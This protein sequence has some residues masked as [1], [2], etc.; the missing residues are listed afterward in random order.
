MSNDEI[1]AAKT[2]WE[3]KNDESLVD[4]LNS[5]T[6]GGLREIIVSLLT[7]KRTEADEADEVRRGV[8]RRLFLVL[9]S[10]T[11]CPDVCFGTSKVG[12]TCWHRCDNWFYRPALFES[13][14]NVGGY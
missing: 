13:V 12:V 10:I 3:A 6:S 14:R 7:G 11:Q 9:D 1:G 5:E 8:H 2:H 4:K